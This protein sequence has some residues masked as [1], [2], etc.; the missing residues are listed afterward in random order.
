MK[1][2]IAAL[3]AARPVLVPVALQLAERLL[4]AAQHAEARR[5]ADRVVPLRPVNDD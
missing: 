3:R 2:L 1:W 5:D 4:A